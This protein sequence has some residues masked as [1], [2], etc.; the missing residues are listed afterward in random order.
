MRDMISQQIRHASTGPRTAP[1]FVENK[2]PMPVPSPVVTASARPTPPAAGSSAPIARK[3]VR[4][5][6]V[7]KDGEPVA[8]GD[9]SASPLPI[10]TLSNSS[11]SEPMPISPRALAPEGKI[12][13]FA[14]PPLPPTV[15]TAS[16]Q[17]SPEIGRSVLVTALVPEA[18]TAS[19]SPTARSPVLITTPVAKQEVLEIP[20]AASKPPSGWI[21]QIGAFPSEDQA[22]S[23][24][25]DARGHAG[26]LLAKGSPYTEV[27]SKGSNKF[28][29]ARFAGFD[30]TT[31]RQA[32]D[33]LKKN[34][35]ACF[36]TRN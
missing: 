28:Y 8:E 17:T 21:V 32:C 22:R 2:I 1:R 3:P 6:S 18:P 16:A 5:V 34:D 31:A 15:S 12:V 29:R 36:T 14:P 23:R 11:V 24:I 19:E 26:G 9:E 7:G 10:N 25:E 30:E 27:T 4:V 13:T 35:F 20:T 33:R